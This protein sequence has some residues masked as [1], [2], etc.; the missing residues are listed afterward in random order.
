MAEH[1]Q[2]ARYNVQIW[3][4]NV[5]NAIVELE[6]VP[7]SLKS[8]IHYPFVQREWQDPVMKDSYRGITQ[9]SVIAKLLESLVLDR[10]RDRLLEAG[11]PHR[12]Q[13][14]RLGEV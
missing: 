14:P 10:M 8:G 12:N 4:R 5:L 11:I 6:V 7:S 1:L 2:E 13:S 9:S 3:L